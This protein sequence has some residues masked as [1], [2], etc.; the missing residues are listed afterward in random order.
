MKAL[1]WMTAIALLLGQPVAR[2]QQVLAHGSA[3][4]PPGSALPP[5][6]IDEPGAKPRSVPLPST[7]IRPSLA[8]AAR[9]GGRDSTNVT[10]RTDASGDTIEEYRS[11]GQVIMVR[12]IPRHGVTQTYKVDN[13]S[14]SLVR[15]PNQGPVAPVYY[16]IYKWGGP[17]KPA[18]GSTVAAPAAASTSGG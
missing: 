14:G 13:A 5:P 2:A 4:P 12:V 7:G 11:G 17:K 18:A 3:P 1:A 16:D 15:D 10:T 9:D 6:G 8:P